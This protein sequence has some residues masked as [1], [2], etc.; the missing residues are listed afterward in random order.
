[1]ALSFY[2][3]TFTITAGTGTQAVSG[4]GF[5]PKV[6]IAYWTRATANATFTAQESFGMGM[7]VDRVTDQQANTEFLNIDNVTTT[8]SAVA[9]V[10]TSFIRNIANVGAGMNVVAAISSFDSD[11]FTINKTTNDGTN[12]HIIKYMAI[13][14]S[15][16]EDAYLEEF[17]SPSGTTGNQAFTGVG[18][19]GNLGLFWGMFGT[20]AG[21]ESAA[22]YEFHFGAA[23]SSSER[24]VVAL[25]GNDGSTGTNQTESYLSDS[26]CLAIPN[27]GNLSFNQVADFVSWDSDG[28]TLN[29]TTSVGTG[30]R[31]YGLILKGTFQSAI[32]Q[33]ARPTS[34]GDQDVT[35]PGFQP[36]GVILAGT[37]ATATATET[38]QGHLALGAGDGTNSHGVW[39][40]ESG[41]NPTDCNMYVSNA[42]VYTQAT[43]PST[44]AAQA[45]LAMLSTGYRLTWGT[46]DATARLFLHVALSSA[47]VTGPNE[48]SVND[49]VTVAE[50]TT[51]HMPI[52]VRMEKLS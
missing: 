6:V 12:L 34:T 52:D 17:T 45:S 30:I 40:G 31:F 21:S 15:D 26:S 22:D 44:I 36:T 41:G 14:G 51:M 23:K 18:F 7:A 50:G 38:V 35:T 9:K 27:G 42:N 28:F 4:V 47:A 43:N 11:G 37:F 29:F 16:L 20:A 46:A 5:Q 13:G 10:G 8:D 24:A 33:Q 48:P 32:A 3:G 39:V 1:M 2:S 25:W 49:G 19:Q